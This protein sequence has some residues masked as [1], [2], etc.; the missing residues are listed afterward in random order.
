MPAHP[1]YTSTQLDEVIAYLRA[2][3]RRKYDPGALE[4]GV[5]Q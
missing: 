2:M 1:A 3:A 4:G 5:T